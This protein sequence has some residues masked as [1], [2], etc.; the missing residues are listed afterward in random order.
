MDRKDFDKIVESH[1]CQVINLAY[2]FLNNHS[3][4]E[5]IAQEVFLRAYKALPDYEPRAQ[6]FTY[7]Y[8][9]TKN[10]CLNY[11]RKKKL[12]Q[13]F[14]LD[15]SRSETDVRAPDFRI[16]FWDRVDG[17]ARQS[18]VT[19]APLSR[20]LI[21]V[22]ASIFIFILGIS[23][24]IKPRIEQI[25]LVNGI[26]DIEFYQDMEVIQNMELL[27]DMEFLMEQDEYNG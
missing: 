12:V 24:F 25:N 16:R 14:S 26:N 10:L 3:D 22:L 15:K 6:Y 21:P 8:K 19:L 11:L 4:A 27:S 20:R 1:Q 17:I 13:F 5:D 2:R 9:I 23:I 7:L 18:R